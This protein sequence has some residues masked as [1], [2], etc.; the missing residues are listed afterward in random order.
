MSKPLKIAVVGGG[1]GG[2]LFAKLVARENPSY[3]I[4]VFEQNPSSATYGFGI[5]LADVALD[6]LESVDLPLHADLLA[7]AEKQ[8][9]ITLYHRRTA[10][11]IRGNVFLGIPRVR[12]LNIMQTH[13]AAEGVNI[14]YSK[15][16]ETLDALSGYD[17]VVG[18]DGVNSAVRQAL[19][20][21]F[22][23]AV[24][25]RL[26]KWVWYG[27]THRFNSVELIFEQTPY[28]IFIAHSY[29]YAPDRGTFVIECHPDTWKNAGLDV[30]T[31]DQ[32]RSFCTEIFKNYLE[33]E[34]LISNRSTWFNPSFVTSQR[35]FS[36]NVVLI[37]DALKT[38]HPSIGSGTRMAFED[39]VALARAIK[40][41]GGDV[42]KSLAAFETARRPSA[43]GFQDAAMRS[44]LWY[45]TADSR[46]H[47][48]PLEFAFSYMMRTGKVTVDR[49]RKID[50]DFLAAY[51]AE[52][53]ARKDIALSDAGR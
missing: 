23:A 15:R 49:L 30:T 38:V 36:G 29:R 31:E 13:A 28:G 27:T 26:N 25:P 19:Q 37:G 18:A 39:A 51:E 42:A 22:A 8:D 5:V 34:E 46:Q 9:T 10:V 16:I 17:L 48:T 44:I 40:A 53:A 33:G 6:F 45:E 32:S 50:P 14:E 20:H 12:L 11:P 3:R 52:A 35:W 2:L 1:P 21:Q 41:A 47:L 4:D 43:D 7:C 24:E